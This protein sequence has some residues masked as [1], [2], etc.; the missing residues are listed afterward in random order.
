MPRASLLQNLH[1]HP[2]PQKTLTSVVMK[3]FECLVLPHLWSITTPHLD[4][5]Q[6]TYRPVDIFP[7]LLQDKL[8]QLSVPDSICR[9]ITDFL[10]DVRL[11]SHV[12]DSLTISTGSPKA[13]FF[14]PFS[15]HCTPTAAPPDTTLIGL[16]SDGDESA[17]RLES[18]HLVTWCR[19][20]NLVLNALKTVEMVVDFRRNPA[21][22][23]P[24]TLH[25]SPVDRH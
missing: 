8:S 23:T 6:F 9:W 19:Q 2:C 7:A 4:P 21:P 17:Y 14:L 22:P 3:T 1:H 25:D 11:G 18:D 10:S 15:S 16:I 12:S 20:N 13:V 24:I 5:L